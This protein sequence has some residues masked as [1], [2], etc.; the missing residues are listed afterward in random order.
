M[1]AFAEKA[2][3]FVRKSHTYNDFEGFTESE[4]I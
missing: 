4:R 2:K 3:D 1:R